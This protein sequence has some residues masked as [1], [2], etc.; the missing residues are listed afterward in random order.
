MSR[1]F[2][3]AAIINCVL[4]TT[5]FATE[6]YLVKVNDPNRL[7]EIISKGGLR[8]VNWIPQ[9][10]I[11]VT[12]PL[13][14]TSLDKLTIQKISDD[15]DVRYLEPSSVWYAIAKPTDPRYGSQTAPRK[16]NL[17]AAWD[18]ETG[19][20]ETLV[21][22]IDT[23]VDYN[24]ED[25]VNRMWTNPNEIPGNSAD[26]DG[27]GYVDD[28]RGWNFAL[29]NSDPK[30]GQFHGTHV[31][32][33]VGAEAN[34]GKGIAGTS[35]NLR[36][37]AVKF[38]GDDGTGRIENAI[39]AIVY[40]ADNGAKI[41]NAS[42]GGGPESQALKDAILY[43]QSKGVLFVAA[44]GN[45]GQDA[46]TKNFYPASFNLPN[47]VTVAALSKSTGLADFSNF[48]KTIIH[49]AAPGQDILSLG[50]GNSYRSESG[51]SM[52][53]PAVSGV[54][55][56]VL[57]AHPNIDVITLKNALLNASQTDSSLSGKLATNGALNAA[58]ALSQ[59]QN[60]F[61]LWPG[62]M[63]L[64]Q[65]AT[66]QMTAYESQ[67]GLNWSSSDGNV[68]TVDAAG[69]VTSHNTGTAVIN[70]QDQTGAS[71]QATIV[72]TSGSS[73]SNPGGGGGCNSKSNPTESSPIALGYL[74]LPLALGLVLRRRKF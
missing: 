50:L 46:E 8:L 13:N 70:V 40:S 24:H 53:A 74:G 7:S 12:E 39:P 26:D 1:I 62:K 43:A 45:N 35:W 38:L 49:L 32:G 37:M 69:V 20:P 25:L 51:T 52:A 41:I 10:N 66:F 60:G 56:L 58:L 9:L 2:I 16:L 65:N 4:S 59:F 33:I 64:S 63:T 47:M 54:A 61:Q 23:G 48:G 67:G 55:A 30:D 6:K 44:A 71:R 31:S 21:S 27:N 29:N 72:V 28:V 17:E 14:K 57:S 5:S 15:K 18:I 36:I 11:A 22:V 42:W 3:T 68:A 73:S 19:K 34:N